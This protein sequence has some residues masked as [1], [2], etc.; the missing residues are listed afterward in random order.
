VKITISDG[1]GRVVREMDGT[2]E[3]GLNRLQWNLAANAPA[4]AGRGF[5]GGGGGGGGRGRGGRGV[6]FITAANAVDPGTYFVKL[7]VG[8]KELMTT[9]QVEADTFR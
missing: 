2:G 6:P 4:A 7:A 1:A 3:A 5:G 9:A 8:G